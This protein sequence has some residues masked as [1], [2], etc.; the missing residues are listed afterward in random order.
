MIG[1]GET[2]PF[3]IWL[4]LQ[5]FCGLLSNKWS[6]ENKPCAP[7]FSANQNKRQS[8]LPSWVWIHPLKYLNFPCWQPRSRRPYVFAAQSRCNAAA[9][10]AHVADAW[11]DPMPFCCAST[12]GSFCCFTSWCPEFFDGE[13]GWWLNFFAGNFCRWKIG[14]CVICVICVISVGN[15]L[16]IY[17]KE[18]GWSGDLDPTAVLFCP[19]LRGLVLPWSQLQCSLGWIFWGRK[20]LQLLG[21]EILS[22]DPKIEIRNMNSL[23]VYM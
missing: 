23:L 6:M 14:S 12:V 13:D 1:F 19:K 3:K 20:R 18:S 5:Q 17:P 4:F 9:S 7:S 15:I 8:H 10:F 11:R 2:K 16:F 22:L 21:F